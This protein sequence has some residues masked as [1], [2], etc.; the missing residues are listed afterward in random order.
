MSSI[1]VK[2]ISD[3]LISASDLLF[4]IYFIFILPY[5]NAR[6]KQIQSVLFEFPNVL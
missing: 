2:H 5:K 3:C 6:Q 4:S 1:N